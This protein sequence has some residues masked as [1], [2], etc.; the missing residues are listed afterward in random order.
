MNEKTRYELFKLIYDYVKNHKEIDA[1]FVDKTIEIMVKS[2]DLHDYVRTVNINTNPQDISSRISLASY[3]YP[4][5][6][7]NVYLHIFKDIFYNSVNLFP[8]NE[9]ER[10]FY[11]Y[12]SLLHIL[13]HELEHAKQF[14]KLYTKTSNNDIEKVLLGSCYRMY[15]VFD[16]DI[17][18]GLYKAGYNDDQ[19]DIYLKQKHQLYED[20]YDF[21][22]HERM[23]ECRSY[24][25]V[26]SILE[27]VKDACPTLL[28]LEQFNLFSN[29]I[30]GYDSSAIPTWNYLT[31]IGNMNDWYTVQRMGLDLNLHDRML[32]GLE[33]KNNE[34][35]AVAN[36]TDD[37]RRKLI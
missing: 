20:N 25:N 7:I 36:Y 23:A 16:L 2:F 10:I 17:I 37:L 5:R 1:N 30:R 33:I 34:Y 31:A 3:S 21:A 9:W 26:I 18:N 35:S 11:I 15:S 32:F 27:L 6:R 24:R 12:F 8:F 19:I 4:I 29:Y 13:S 28:T 22:P 14:K